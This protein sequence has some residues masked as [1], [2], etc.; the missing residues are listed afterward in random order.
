VDRCLALQ[1]LANFARLAL[2]EA[3]GALIISQSTAHTGLDEEDRIKISQ[4]SGA[5]DLW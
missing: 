4:V 3:Q 5:V 2:I 1:R